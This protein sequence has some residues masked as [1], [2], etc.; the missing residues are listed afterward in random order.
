MKNVLNIGAPYLLLLRSHPTIQTKNSTN[1][2]LHH[3]FQHTLPEIDTNPVWI[4]E[5]QTRFLHQLQREQTSMSIR[6]LPILTLLER[7]LPCLTLRF[8]IVSIKE[9][10]S[11]LSS[12]GQTAIFCNYSMTNQ[13]FS[14]KHIVIKAQHLDTISKWCDIKLRQVLHKVALH[15]LCIL[16]HKS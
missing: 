6:L 16:P 4:H 7:G 12:S 10:S 1:S 3:K 8:C 11:K 15:H 14:N 9:V 13:L 2:M 5:D